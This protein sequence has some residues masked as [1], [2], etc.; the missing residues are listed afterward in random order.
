[1]QNENNFVKISI[2]FEMKIEKIIKF[3][4]DTTIDEI[5]QFFLSKFLFKN[6]DDL[7]GLQSKNR[8]LN[9]RD[10]KTSLANFNQKEFNFNI[11]EVINKMFKNKKIVFFFLVRSFR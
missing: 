7:D 6:K 1:M 5:E 11:G 4:G 10:K 2:N 3:P 8:K 9:L